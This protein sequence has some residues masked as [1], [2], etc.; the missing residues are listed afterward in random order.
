VLIGRRHRVNVDPAHLL[1]R[2]IKPAATSSASEQAAGCGLFVLYFGTTR[3]YLT[4]AH[5]T[6]WMGERYC[7]F[8]RHLSSG[9]PE[10]FS[11][12]HR[13]KRRKTT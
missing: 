2:W 4:V 7:N 5:H 3:T 6:I 12:L 11:L 10:D 9:C 13:M 8:G 1:A